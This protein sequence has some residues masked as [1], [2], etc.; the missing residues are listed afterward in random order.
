MIK[1]FLAPPIFENQ[2]QTHTASQL[3][4][5][6]LGMTGMSTVYLI[7]WLIFVPDISERIIFALP[8][9]PLFGWLFYLLRKGKIKMAGNILV[10]G[11]WITLFVATS[12]SGGVLAPGYSGLLITVLAAGIFM[13]K[14]WAVRIA[15]LSIIGGGVLVYLERQ[16]TMPAAAFTDST[17]MWIA[18][19]VYFFVGVSLLQM[20]TQR[21][22][23]ALQR[24]EREIEQ[25]RKTE[26]Q[27]RDAER[28][29]RELVE[30]VPAVMY[31]AEIGAAGKWSY[32]SPRIELLTGYTP[33]EWTAD[34]HLWYERVHPDDRE[35]VVVNEVRALAEGRQFYSEYRFFRRNGEL[36]WIRDES[37][38]VV[39]ESAVRSKQVQGFLLDITELRGAREAL[40]EAELLYRT[41][42]EETS[43]VIYRDTAVEGGPSL[44]ISPQIENLI[45]YSP[46]EFSTQP[47]FWQSLLHPDDKEMVFDVIDQILATGKSITCEYRLK[48]KSGNW[49]WLRDEAALVKDKN[50]KPRY[51]QGVYVD[52]TKQKVMEEQRESLIN[53]LEAKNTEL[54]RFTY[55]VSHDLKAPL[56]TM[57]G[58]LGFL[59][60]DAIS[61]NTQRLKSDIHRIS[62]ANLKM[63]QLL[64]ELLELSRIGRLINPPEEV[65]FEHIIKDALSRVES[66]LNKRQIE[67]KIG[68]GLPLV[69]G[70]RMRLVEVIQ[71]LVDN[72][73]KFMGSQPN[74]EI[75]IGAKSVGGQDCLLCM[76]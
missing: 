60:N 17:T 11:L 16:G 19:A 39:N 53:E 63:Q 64:N 43:V 69:R 10:G 32:V 55:T 74:P 52:I 68:S 56:I 73:A 33:E 20:A 61:G 26:D 62:E 51:I 37:L 3:W 31:T 21:I 8:L 14:G 75:E 50:G 23:N 1:K 44:F 28:R 5:V 76:R 7:A 65:A 45:G 47:D 22:S 24:A 13:S 9:Y 58:F 25:R 49:V 38:A 71:N 27:L 30:S 57:G 72:A 54:E 34:A 18:Q 48:S 35:E 6:V 29:Y 36:I 2:E 42:V 70:D 4:T 46:A 59:E 40:Q 12:F 67:V 66:Q 15:W 41:L